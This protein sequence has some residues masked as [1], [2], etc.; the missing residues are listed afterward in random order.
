MSGSCNTVT[1]K[2]HL[3]TVHLN[4]DIFL[5]TRFQL[6]LISGYQGMRKTGIQSCSLA[7]KVVDLNSLVCKSLEIKD[8][9]SNQ[10]ITSNC[11]FFHI[12]FESLLLLRH[13]KACIYGKVKKQNGHD[14]PISLT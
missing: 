1:E 14:G 5:I 12:V 10:L 4:N 7:L 3:Q 11:S 6:L 13:Q 2:A 8:G 9:L